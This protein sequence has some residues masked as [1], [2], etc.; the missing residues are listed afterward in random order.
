MIAEPT[1]IVTLDVD[2]AADWMIEMAAEV[3]VERGVKATWFITH[4][5]PALETLRKEPLF[6]LGWHPNFLPNSSHGETPEAVLTYCQG[7][8]PEARSVRTHSLCQS[9]RHLS[10]MVEAFNIK[11]DCSIYLPVDSAIDAHSVGYSE[12][13]PKLTRVPHFFQDNMHMYT[14]KS[15]DLSR[16]MLERTGVLVF[17]FHP[18]HI[19]LNSLNMAQYEETKREMNISTIKKEDLPPIDHSSSGA[20]KLFRDV[21]DYAS[22]MSTATLNEYCESWRSGKIDG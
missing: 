6:E 19:A 5:S 13:G 7:L 15:W 17:C 2:W 21:A 16:S 12:S 18:V 14:G 10:L 20:G 11:N 22:T 8:V 9:E 4:E 3:L 1:I